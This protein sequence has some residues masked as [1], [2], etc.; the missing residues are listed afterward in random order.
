[1]VLYS[2]RRSPAIVEAFSKNFLTLSESPRYSA[3]PPAILYHTSARV[4]FPLESKVVA[5][6]TAS[7]NEV[8]IFFGSRKR[9]LDRNRY[10]SASPTVVSCSLLRTSGSW[11]SGGFPV[12]D[13]WFSFLPNRPNISRPLLPLAEGQPQA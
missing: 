4:L 9:R 6:L 1:M 7:S 13:G 10:I 12:G 3:I 2:G 11:L 8:V 5:W